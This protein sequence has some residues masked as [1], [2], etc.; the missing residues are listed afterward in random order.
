MPPKKAK[1]R[2]KTAPARARVT[3]VIM[4][5]GTCD[6]DE[7]TAE[8]V[9]GLCRECRV[10][11]ALETQDGTPVPVVPQTFLSG[12][13]P[14]VVDVARWAAEVREAGGLRS[15]AGRRR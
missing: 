11:L 9:D 2:Q 1:A 6:A 7:R 10:G 8:I 5:C 3:R 14:D 4:A 15:K 12:P 13:A